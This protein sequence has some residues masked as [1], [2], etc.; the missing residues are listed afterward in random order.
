MELRVKW[1]NQT[2]V[3]KR[4][5]MN[6][7]RLGHAV[8]E[9]MREAAEDT[10]DEIHFRGVE[11]IEDAGN[12]G[13][14]WTEAFHADVTET[15]R[16]IRVDVSMQP[17]GPPVIY[18]PV[19]EYGA[20]ITAKNP[21]GYMWLPFKGAEGTD[22]WPRAYDGDLFRATSKR[23]TP[24]LGDRDT[25]EWKY[26]GLPEVTIPKKFHLEQIVREEATKAGRQFKAILDKI[27]SQD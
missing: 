26:F 27:T 24:L 8:R 17:D 2:E 6:M 16:T 21:S 3:E 9:A 14:R 4:I 7:D 15:Q 11:D 10:S 5:K 20:H 22:V 25:G 23:G 12:F 13:E 19:F 18:W 1:N